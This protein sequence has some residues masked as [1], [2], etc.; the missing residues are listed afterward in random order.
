MIVPAGG[1]WTRSVSV[2]VMPA[3]CGS[4][5]GASSCSMRR[6]RSAANSAL[7]LIGMSGWRSASS[8]SAI[9]PPL[10]VGAPKRDAGSDEQRHGGVHAATEVLGA[11]RH[12]EVVEVAQ[13]Q[14]AAM[15]GAEPFE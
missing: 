6:R 4:G 8:G 10:L 2:V 3:P 15:V 7:G 12:R 1:A 14:G 9:A 11:L 13:R 5:S